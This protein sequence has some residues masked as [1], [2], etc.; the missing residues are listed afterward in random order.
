MKHAQHRAPREGGVKNTLIALFL[1]VFLGGLCYALYPVAT[2]VTHEIESRKVV[3][4]FLHTIPANLPSNTASQDFD[5]H[6]S[7]EP[8]ET[9]YPELLSAMQSY[10]EAIYAEGQSGLVDA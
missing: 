10:N 5:N 9:P 4:D 3:D 6:S 2:G 1:L 7:I 8:T